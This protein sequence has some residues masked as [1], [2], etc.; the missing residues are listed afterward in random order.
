[1]TSRPLSFR[2]RLAIAYS[3]ILVVV[4]A[5]FGAGLYLLVRD[6]MLSHHDGEL[7]E[8]AAA[9]GSV[10]AQHEDCAQLTTA[11]VQELNR[12][13]K[14]VLFH[15]A[16]GHPD[17]FYRS[18]DLASVPGARELAARPQLLEEE[19]GF[20]T[21]VEDGDHVRVYSVPYRSRAGRRGVIRVLERMG[22]V[23][24]PLRNLRLGLLL[25]APA[26]IALSALVT[27]SRAP[28]APAPGVAGTAL[29]RE[30]EATQ[31]SRRLPVPPVRDEIGRLVET[32][33]QMIGRLES[34]FE[35]MKR[36]T[37]DA[38]HELRSP[39]T[40]VK[41][42][43]E[44][45][46]DRPREAAEYRS[47]LASVGEEAE[48]LRRIVEDLLLLA[49]ADSGRLP[50]EREPLRLDVLAKEVA[51]SFGPRALEAGLRVEADAESEVVVLGDERWLRQL[52]QNLVENAVR[53]SPRSGKPAPLVAI[54]VRADGEDALLVVEDEG[55]GIPEAERE[56]IFERFYRVDASRQ[57]GAGTG[58]GLGL[59]ICSWIV[60]AH[61][62]RIEAS[63]RAGGG[64][65]IRVRL[66]RG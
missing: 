11:Q 17:V 40:N 57:R 28:R 47:A 54:G 10:L 27:W 64:T 7:E 53:F 24:L 13:S 2:A 38:S 23:E 49:R 33:N 39:L 31:L 44:L 62:G 36:F 58:A 25:L 37:A 18:P 3:G 34:S 59:A 45:A 6:Q 22:D 50:F 20:R 16:G 8:T 61:R 46:L 14:L 12:Y 15:S 55:P 29:A 63:G 21:F 65:V 60:D 43:V 5:L 9:V 30:I 48:R 66:P 1:M 4:L 35:A 56:R 52:V 42:T 41:S 51:E 19:P 32:F 26:A